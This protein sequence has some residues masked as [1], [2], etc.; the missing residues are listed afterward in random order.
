[1]AKEEFT[2]GIQMVMFAGMLKVLLDRLA[3]EDKA[4][5]MRVRRI[6][7]GEWEVSMLTTTANYD[8]FNN[9]LSDPEKWKNN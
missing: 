2:K 6:K 7:R 5:D 4:F 9:L 1:M 8:Y 3:N